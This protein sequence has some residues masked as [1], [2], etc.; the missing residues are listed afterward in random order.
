MKSTCKFCW[1]ISLVL[2]VALGL[3]V[4]KVVVVGSV[5]PYAD[6]RV[7]VLLLPNERNKVLAEMRGLLESVQAVTEAAV[8]GDMAAIETTARAVGMAAAEAESPA[9]MSKLPL[10][11]KTLG[12]ATHKA[13]DDLA[14]LAAGGAEPMAVIANLSQ[15]ML[16]CTACHQGYRLGVVGENDE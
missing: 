7:S 2:A 16:N 15:V 5:A 12:L 11:F 13:F 1:L 8:A 14:D 10:E 4:Y 9:M 6:G 3:G